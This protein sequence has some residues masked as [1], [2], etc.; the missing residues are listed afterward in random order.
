MTRIT[1]ESPFPGRGV[2]WVG[3]SWGEV[4]EYYADYSA[5]SPFGD[6]HFYR[7]SGRLYLCHFGGR[8]DPTLRQAIPKSLEAFTLEA[9]TKSLGQIEEGRRHG[10]LW[11]DM[12]KPDLVPLPGTDN[13]C[14][15]AFAILAE[16]HADQ[17]TP[18]KLSVKRIAA[19]AG[20]ISDG[21]RVFEIAPCWRWRYLVVTLGGDTVAE[22][23]QR[24]HFQAPE[25]MALAVMEAIEARADMGRGGTPFDDP[26]GAWRYANDGWTKT[27]LTPEGETA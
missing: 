19:P 13:D 24:D 4:I 25:R 11:G 15:K 23:D 2:F 1:T 18:K 27:E 8:G 22:I 5:H 3:K 16:H 7:E 20:T 6:G 17:A 14:Q 21:T 26:D 9:V 10:P 12:P